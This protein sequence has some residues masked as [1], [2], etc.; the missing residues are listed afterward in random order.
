MKRTYMEYKAPEI[1]VI[2]S[3]AGK[4]FCGSVVESN[5]TE[6]FIE[7]DDDIIIF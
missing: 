7:G 3:T 6:K 4:C 2:E 1:I 5:S